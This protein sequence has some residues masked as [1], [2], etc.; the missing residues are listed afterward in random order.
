M[1]EQYLNLST[2]DGLQSVA[3][4]AVQSVHFQ[5]AVLEGEFQRALKVLATSHDMQKKAVSLSFADNGKR[6]V[7]VGYVVDRP[8]WK[9]SY[10]LSV[11]EKGKISLQGWALVDNPSDDDWND[12]R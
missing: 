9:T 11:D 6:A 8:I 5:N 1:D 3:M 10:R 4:N 12:V 7:R 2:A